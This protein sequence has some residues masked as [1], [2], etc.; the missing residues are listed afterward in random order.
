MCYIYTCHAVTVTR[1]AQAT[2]VLSGFLSSHLY[3][4]LS[5]PPMSIEIEQPPTFLNPWESPRVEK[6]PPRPA[7][8]KA[9]SWKEYNPLAKRL[10]IRD[11]EQANEE[12]SKLNATVLGFDL[13]W[14]PNFFRGNKENPV[15]LVQ[16]ANYDTILLLQISAMEGRPDRQSQVLNC[17]RLFRLYR[18]SFKTSRAPS[19]L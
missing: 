16:L 3:F 15:A 11:H 6:Y 14:K 13:E 7:P 9:Y 10:Y 19:R 18:N 8:T 2:S 1:L 4:K 17:N 5:S 12:L